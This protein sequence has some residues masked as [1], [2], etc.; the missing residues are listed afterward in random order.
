VAGICG[1]SEARSGVDQVQAVLR[2]ATDAALSA[3]STRACS[4]NRDETMSE[5]RHLPKQ[6]DGPPAFDPRIAH[7]IGDDAPALLR[8]WIASEIART[9]PARSD[10]TDAVVHRAA[11][12][13]ADRFSSPIRSAIHAMLRWAMSIAPRSRR[14]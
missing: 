7:Q 5:P 2:G 3:R 11:P 8:R 10:A 14:V 9:R 6:P 12:T 1:L 4:S 13:A